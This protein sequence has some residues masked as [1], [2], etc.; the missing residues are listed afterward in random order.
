MTSAVKSISNALGFSS[1]DMPGIPSIKPPKDVLN[2]ILGVETRI[3]KDEEGND[4]IMNSLNLSPEDQARLDQ[5][6]STFDNYLVDLKNL[7]TITAAIDDPTYEPVLNAVRDQQAMARKA[8]YNERAM[9]EEDTLAKRGLADSTAGSTVRDA[10]GKALQDQVE[11]D[12]TNLVLMAE[13]LRDQQIQ[14]TGQTLEFATN[15]L[16]FDTA[17]RV[18]QGNVNFAQ[19][20]QLFGNENAQQQNYYSNLM[21]QYQAKV[22]QDQAVF[23]NFLTLGT[24]IATGGGYK[25]G[26]DAGK[27]AGTAG[28]STGGSTLGFPSMTF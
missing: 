24:S 20:Q 1:R 14:R 28:Q 9:L 4:V 13:Q 22:A 23:D 7:T 27:A 11:M 18:N 6:E 17:A 26:L 15:K 21:G 5:L 12:E 16:N 3:T 10:R 19:Q 25:T 2:Q 8:A